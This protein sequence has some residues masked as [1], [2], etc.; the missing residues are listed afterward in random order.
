[1]KKVLWKVGVLCMSLSSMWGLS[2]TPNQIEYAHDLSNHPDRPGYL[3]PG[4]SRVY[5]FIAEEDGTVDIYTTGDQ[6]TVGYFFSDN[7]YMQDDIADDINYPSN[8]NFA[9][10]NIRVEKN[11]MYFVVVK[12]YNDNQRGSF[13]IH[14]RTHYSPEQIPDSSTRWDTGVWNNY[15]SRVK[16]LEVPGASDLVVKINGSTEEYY[17][18][19]VIKNSQ[20]NVVRELTGQID[21]EFGVSDSKIIV[22]LVSDYSK[23][24][25]GV[26]ITVKEYDNSY[27]IPFYYGN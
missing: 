18:K 16:T 10:N 2:L 24:S 14:L 15:E 20:G 4:L 3:S 1:M 17:D 13:G 27:Y 5:S 8:T 9:F 6:D 23:E 25:D 22:E 12:G 21:E 7:L 11:K 26:V 19:V